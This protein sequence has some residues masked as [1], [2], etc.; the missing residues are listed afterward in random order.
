MVMSREQNERMTRVGAVTPGGEML[1]RYWWPIAFTDEIQTKPFRTRLLGEDLVLFRD[2][3][4]KV[5]L[6]ARACPH[7]GAGLEL[8]RVE[9]DGIRCCYHGWKFD[10][11]GACLDMP[12]EPADTPLRRE[13][14]QTAYVTEEAAGIVF[15]YMGPTPAP[16]FPR[17]D[18]VVREDVNREVY[19]K[20]DY[21]NWLQR[22]ENG[23]D[24][25]HLGVLHAAG[26][27]QL[28]FKRPAV[29]RERMWYGFRTSSQFPGGALNVSHQIFPSHTRRTGSRRGEAPRHYIHFRVPIDNELTT[30][31][32][33]RAEILPGEQKGKTEFLGR[34]ESVRGV[35]GHVDDGWWGIPS[36]EQDRAA[37][38]SQGLIFDRS[39]E[40]LGTTDENI[41]LFRRMVEDAIRA[42]EE[43]RD[44]PGV[45]RTPPEGDMIRFDATKNFADGVMQA[46]DM[47]GA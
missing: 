39:K 8:G 27:P 30:T 43:G 18:L 40:C 15:A 38:E 5:G 2:G 23:H 25:A 44:P 29:T 36:R 3:S 26:Y 17:I 6:V 19:A 47:I 12:A 14:R 42:V 13:V 1:R 31:F 21:C 11:A 4:G 45:L 24:P 37:Q 28:A 33:I 20:D 35:Y 32:Y 10:R 46:P 16:V 34:E 9:E 41:V 7:R 22:A